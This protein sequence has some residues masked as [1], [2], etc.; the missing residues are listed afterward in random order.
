MLG[1]SN[2][3]LRT[4]YR[5]KFFLLLGGVNRRLLDRLGLSPFIFGFDLGFGASFLRIIFFGF[6]GYLFNRLWECRN[7]LFQIFVVSGSQRPQVL[8]NFVFGI[9]KLLK[10]VYL[11]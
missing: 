10:S 4:N 11:D 6:L 3:A 9:N 8:L 7:L 5:L 2:V 1:L